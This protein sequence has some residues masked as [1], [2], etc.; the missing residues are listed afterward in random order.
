MPGSIP[1]SSRT[2]DGYITTQ[3]GIF[4]DLLEQ[5][6]LN[7]LP[8]ISG[9]W[10]SIWID[11]DVPPDADSSTYPINVRVET[12]SGEVLGTGSL[13]LT[14]IGAVLPELSIP[15][16]RWFHTDCLATYYG[17]DVFS[18]RHWEVIENFLDYTIK[19]GQNMV[20]TPIHTPPLD[21]EVGGE[22]PTVQLIDVSVDGDK[23][24]FGFEKLDKW[25]KCASIQA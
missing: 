13:N 18:D 4:P 3:A 21:T 20:L 17:V 2:D 23:Y 5:F 9:Q 25:V 7:R 19:H 12:P 1:K 24:T 8:L 22:R 10:Q 6:D 16:T 14:V 15:Y 11:I